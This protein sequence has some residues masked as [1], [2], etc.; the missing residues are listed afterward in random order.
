MNALNEAEDTTAVRFD[1]LLGIVAT[2][3]CAM[4]SVLVYEGGRRRRIRRFC[5]TEQSRYSL[6]R[7][8]L[9]CRH[10]VPFDGI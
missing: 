5:L 4:A 3:C 9:K 10:V 6:G 1:C 7:N 8:I 2:A